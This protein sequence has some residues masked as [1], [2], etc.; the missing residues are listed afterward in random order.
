MGCNRQGGERERRDDT[1]SAFLDQRLVQRPM[2]Y[3]HHPPRGPL[4][5]FHSFHARHPAPGR[6][7]GQAISQEARR[8]YSSFQTRSSLPDLLPR[9]FFEPPGKNAMRLRP[10]P[11]WA[12][13]VF[14]KVV[15][16][17]IAKALH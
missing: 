5:L 17:K 9:L 6:P 11:G 16:A 3:P 8:R 14:G 13:V 15:K 2:R 4:G 1:Q 7:A 12:K 10:T